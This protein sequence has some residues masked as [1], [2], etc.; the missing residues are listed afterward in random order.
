[1]Q[2]LHPCASLVPLLWFH[3]LSW[4]KL[5]CLSTVHNVPQQAPHRSHRYPSVGILLWCALYLFFSFSFSFF[6]WRELYRQSLFLTPH[7]KHIPQG[8]LNIKARVWGYNPFEM[9]LSVITSQT[10]LEPSLALRSDLP[11]CLAQPL[12]LPGLQQRLHT[13]MLVLPLVCVPANYLL[14]GSIQC[15]V[16]LP[17]LLYS[18]Q[19]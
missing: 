3:N 18:L 12:T 9:Q 14:N 19:S 17:R 7:T 11:R 2:H 13:G 1:M 6:A 10:G 5:L 4:I 8:G 16:P 15:F